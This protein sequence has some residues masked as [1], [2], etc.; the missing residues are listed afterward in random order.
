LR[1]LRLLDVS[2]AEIDAAV[3]APITQAKD[4]SWDEKIEDKN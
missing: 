1:D 3:S 2:P 4:G